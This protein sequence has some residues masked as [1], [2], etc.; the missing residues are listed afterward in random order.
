[1]DL[2]SILLKTMLQSSSVNSVAKKTGVKSDMVTKLLRIGLPLLILYLT[3]NAKSKDGA[4][5][6]LSA[7]GQHKNDKKVE[8]QLAEADAVDGD[9]IL[10]HIFGK[11]KDNVLSQIASQAGTSKK[12]ANSVLSNITPVLLSLLLSSTMSAKKKKKQGFDLS[13]G[14]D[15]T[16]V[17]ALVGSASG[18]QSGGGIAGDLLGTLLGGGQTQAKPQAKP[19]QQ[20]VQATD[21]LS[22]LLGAGQ[23]QA[24][25]QQQQTVQATDI[26]STLLG[27]GQA[28]AQP[29]QPQAADILSTLLGSGQLSK[30]E[31]NGTELITSLLSMMK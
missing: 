17:L 25:P 28:Q 24:K 5:S 30:K 14:L 7:I 19:Q 1:M 16:D 18:Q 21:I 2:L 10:G 23:A 15:L 29:Q 20:T 8:D 13:D 12:E 9:K 27:A 11:D 22:T 6:L 3:K 31:V 4:S 26:L